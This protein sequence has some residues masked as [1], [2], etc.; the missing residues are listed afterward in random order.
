MR[1]YSQKDKQA[2]GEKG[3]SLITD[4]LRKAGL[5]NYKLINAGYGTVFDKLIIPPE[6]GYAVEIKV[7]QVPRIA[8]NVKSITPNERRGLERFMKLVGKDNA[9][10]IG[11]WKTEEFQRAYLI[12]WA[13]VREQVLSGIRGSINMLD[14]PELPKRGSGWD[15]SVFNV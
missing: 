9:F 14:F 2:R 8:H 6:G 12:R 1:K 10:I 11:I 13:D 15:M 5:W 7:R 4:S 3:E